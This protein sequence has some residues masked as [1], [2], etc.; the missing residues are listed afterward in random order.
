[1]TNF[2]E[3]YRSGSLDSLFDECYRVGSLDSLK[4]TAGKKIYPRELSHI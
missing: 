1:M 4:N 2:D 3:C